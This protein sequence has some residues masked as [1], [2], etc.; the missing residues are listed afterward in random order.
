MATALLLDRIYKHLT[1]PG[2]PERPERYDAVTAGL[3]REGLV[4][5]AM[6]V[7]P[8]PAS[9]DEIAMC[10]TRDYIA[11]VKRDIG[12]GL[13]ELSTGDTAVSPRSLDV[14]LEAAGGV[15]NAVDAVM[16]GR[17]KH[18]FCAVRPPGH[19]ASAVRGMGF[20]V[21]NNIAIGARS[22]QKKHGVGSVSLHNSLNSIIAG[23]A[24]ILW[25][26][27]EA[28][29][30][31]L[32]ADFDILALLAELLVPAFEGVFSRR[33]AFDRKRALAVGHTEE[34]MVHHK[35]I[36][37]HPGMDITLDFDFPLGLGEDPLADFRIGRLAN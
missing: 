15:M 30:E 3:E 11:T 21:F 19:H 31:S 1:G 2:H 6:R 23:L 9:E 17:T 5:D 24:T 7:T 33:K 28:H 8:R 16:G 10:H 36:G 25:L 12:R 20:C 32:A 29:V 4:R 22:A 26:K 18:A 34:R 14:A 35:Y 13:H 37:V 27:R